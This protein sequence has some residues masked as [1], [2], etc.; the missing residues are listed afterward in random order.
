MV[1]PVRRLADILNRVRQP[2]NNNMLALVAAEAALTDFEHLQNTIAVNTQ[3]MQQ[4]TDGFKDLGLG[5]DSIG[6]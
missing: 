2:F 3:G 4:L 6:R 5:V 1:C